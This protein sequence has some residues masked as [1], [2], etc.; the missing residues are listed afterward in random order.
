M[1]K[2]KL[3]PKATLILLL[4]GVL[5]V[6]S[7]TP[8]RELYKQWQEV[9]GLE[10]ELSSV[11]RQNEKLKEEVERLKTDAYIEQQ[12][13]ARLGL[14]KPGEQAYVIVPPRQSVKEEKA[15]EEARKKAEKKTQAKE[16]T[17]WQKIIS[18]FQSLL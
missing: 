14:V 5:I 3:T 15:R 18:F 4:A 17:I 8:A 9:K 7:I 10:K 16:K 2:V 12:A 6:F 1:R 13:R 11:R